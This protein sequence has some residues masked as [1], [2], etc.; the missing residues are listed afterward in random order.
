MRTDSEAERIDS[1]E[2]GSTPGRCANARL[3]P[4]SA[5]RSLRPTLRGLAGRSCAARCLHRLLAI[6]LLPSLSDLRP[7]PTLQNCLR[8]RAALILGGENLARLT[9]LQSACRNSMGGRVPGKAPPL[10]AQKDRLPVACRETRAPVRNCTVRVRVGTA[11]RCEAHGPHAGPRRSRALQQ[12]RGRRG[13][14]LGDRVFNSA[15]TV[16]ASRQ[17][18]PAEGS[19]ASPCVIRPC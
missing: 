2:P 11:T 5:R 3:A 18:G 6:L 14:A 19:E 12:R 17:P 13:A 15:E 4:S 8:P 16:A 7:T 9:P 1:T 10:Q